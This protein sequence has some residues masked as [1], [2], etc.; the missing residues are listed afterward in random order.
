MPDSTDARGPECEVPIIEELRD[1]TESL[2]V[3]LT[4][5]EFEERADRA[6]RRM[7]KADELTVALREWAKARKAQIEDLR[8]EAHRALR[9][10]RERARYDEVKVLELLHEDGIV[11]RVREDTGEILS[12][13]AATPD[14][15]QGHLFA[16]ERHRQARETASE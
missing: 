11:R 1:T 6:A 4:E 15:R 10:I 2:P 14:E 9:E 16:L 5:S 12:Q 7:A 3:P 8:Q 13:R